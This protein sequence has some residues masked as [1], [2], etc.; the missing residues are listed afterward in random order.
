[1]K[2][3]KCNYTSFDHYQSC[4]KCNRDL[5][6]ARERMGFLSYVNCGPALFTAADDS[7]AETV[8]T[9]A[10]VGAT[11]EMTMDFQDTDLQ[12]QSAA[13]PTEEA[14]EELSFDFEEDFAFDDQ[15]PA[16]P[17]SK[18]GAPIEDTMDA[19]LDFSLKDASEELTLDLDEPSGVPKEIAASEDDATSDGEI[20]FSFDVAEEDAT[21]GSFDTEDMS[22]ETDKDVTAELE[23]SVSALVDSIEFKEE[24]S[25]TADNNDSAD[26]EVL[27][28]DLDLEDIDEK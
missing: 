20:D 8:Q 23:K 10:S 3:P 19:D 22:E 24:A 28:L 12:T 1:M 26:M 14:S 13:P 25:E 16:A 27:D 9:G 21:T 17:P 4:P 6:L 2:C 18:T 15:P 5:N 11:D 7:A